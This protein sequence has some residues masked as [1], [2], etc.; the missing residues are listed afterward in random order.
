[1]DVDNEATQIL[2][3]DLGIFAKGDPQLESEAR[4]VAESVLLDGAIEKGILDK[5]DENAITV[6]T[7]FF[8]SLGYSDV[9]V[10]FENQS[11]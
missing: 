4:R 2:D 8:T 5:A 1:V 10:S 6:L 9:V 7:N 3:R 11:G